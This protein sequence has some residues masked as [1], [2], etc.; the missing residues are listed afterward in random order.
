MPE[1]VEKFE[2]YTEQSID[3]AVQLAWEEGA[4]LIDVLDKVRSVYQRQDL[5]VARG[6]WSND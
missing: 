4:L 3:S 2:T 6:E 5:A 1:S